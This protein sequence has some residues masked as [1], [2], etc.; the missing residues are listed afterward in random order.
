MKRRDALRVLG[1]SAGAVALARP[2]PV[3]AMTP[4]TDDPVAVLVDTTRC[5]GCRMCEFACA[6][7]NGLPEPDGATEPSPD[8]DTST[9]QWTVVKGYT[10]GERTVTVKRQC[11][12][13]LQP[14]CAVGCL[15]RALRKTP[16]G[17]VTW[18][19]GK[20]MGCRY[21]MLSC[22]FDV[23]RFEYDSANPRIEKCQLC[24][25]RVARGQRPACVEACPAQALLFGRR[26]N[27]LEEARTRIYTHPDQYVH[28][29]YGER[30]VGGTSWLYLSAVPFEQIGFRTDLATTAY[31]LYT[32]EF[33]Y[34][35]PL[36]LTLVPP[37]LLGLR[38]GTAGAHED[39][40]EGG[41]P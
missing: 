4:E 8:R 2:R 13:C 31:P 33:L 7:A 22:P 15:T 25:A 26:N 29:I 23:P 35:V 12:H 11:M 40:D 36:V 32:K 41:Q 30:E 9:T 34:A 19:G 18:D 37:L 14:A 39:E 6:E 24:S 10:V 1:L 16:D 5:I 17:P 27:L 21:C 38:R 20:C 28:Q 3:Q